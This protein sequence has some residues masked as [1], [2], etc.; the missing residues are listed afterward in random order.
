MYLCVYWV[1]SDFIN[2]ITH[3]YNSDEVSQWYYLYYRIVEYI[4]IVPI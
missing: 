3:C 4:I 2:I 1:L